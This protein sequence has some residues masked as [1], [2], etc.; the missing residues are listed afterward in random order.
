M[1]SI[2]IDAA[3]VF[4]DLYSNQDIQVSITN[5]LF[6]EGVSDGSVCFNFLIPNTPNNSSI[7]GFP[8]RLSRAFQVF[9]I[10]LNVS[11]FWKYTF[12]KI[13][14]LVVRKANENNIE[15]SIGL[16]ESVIVADKGNVTLP[17][18]FGDLSR[19]LSS[20]HP[21]SPW[22]TQP[23]DLMRFQ[24]TENMKSDSLSGYPNKNVCWPMFSNPNS[25]GSL[26]S[27]VDNIKSLYSDHW[28]IVNYYRENSYNTALDYLYE[29][30]I[31]NIFSPQI[32]NSFILD[33]VFENFLV[34]NNIFKDDPELNSLFLFN[35]YIMAYLIPNYFYP[36][37]STRMTCNNKFFYKDLVPNVTVSQ[38]LSALFN[39]FN[40]RAYVDNDNI[41]S[42]LSATSIINSQELLELKPGSISNISNIDVENSV[43][44]FKYSMQKISDGYQNIYVQSLDDCNI[45]GFVASAFDLPGG[46]N[47]YNDAYFVVFNKKWY[48]WGFNEDTNQ[49]SWVA[50]SLD[51]LYDFYDENIFINP[52]RNSDFTWST[53][54]G[55]IISPEFTHE[56]QNDAG[57]SRS[58]RIPH[59]SKAAYV[60]GMNE[61]ASEKWDNISFLFYRGMQKSSISNDPFPLASHDNVYPYDPALVFNYNLKWHGENG[62]FEKFHKPYF[63]LLKNAI[64][65]KC[66]LN[67]TEAKLF[68]LDIT[69]KYM[70]DNMVLFFKKI[71]FTLA[72]SSIKNVTAEAYRI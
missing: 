4:L 49:N 28:P 20:Y 46:N 52:D 18:L 54:A 47:N 29:K 36:D 15:V 9:N 10:K 58:I 34:Q 35:P 70:A 66:D 25:L 72:G 27:T 30:P 40:C 21:L 13:G 68:R 51:F 26:R 2:R 16:N 6:S 14:I 62:L 45:K 3:N 24:V 48:V 1:L 8:S 43:S 61:T 5:P 38:Y 31:L 69:K 67:I 37:T 23:I 41:F 56:D 60:H 50:H 22:W 11:L 44:K 63:E 55:T 65:F 19:S 42:I 39:M 71:D 64:L 32:Y 57:A 59:I 53:E 7:L 12:W 33:T 17:E